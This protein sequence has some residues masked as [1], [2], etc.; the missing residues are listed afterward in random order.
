MANHDIQ[1]SIHLLKRLEDEMNILRNI[2]AQAQ[3]ASSNLRGTWNA[4]DVTHINWKRDIIE[5]S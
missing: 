5:D 2:L 1:T 4:I 3:M